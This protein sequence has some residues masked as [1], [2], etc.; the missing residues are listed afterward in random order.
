MRNGTYRRCDKLTL[1]G[2]RSRLICGSV[3]AGHVRCT[4]AD[5]SCTP[6]RPASPVWNASVVVLRRRRR[7]ADT[8]RGAAS[9]VTSRPPA[10]VRAGAHPYQRIG[11]A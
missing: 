7:N 8:I 1:V 2:T 9:D 11:I 3:S 10:A 5:D 4:A 6:A